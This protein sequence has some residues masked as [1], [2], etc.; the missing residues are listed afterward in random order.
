MDNLY[1]N[2]FGFYKQF[3]YENFYRIYQHLDFP[4]NQRKYVVFSEVMHQS[5]CEFQ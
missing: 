5:L 2:M 1:K 3:R 4:A